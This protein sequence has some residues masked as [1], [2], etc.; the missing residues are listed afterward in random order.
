MRR[1]DG[2]EKGKASEEGEAGKEDFEEGKEVT[3]RRALA[4]QRPFILI[5]VSPLVRLVRTQRV[6]GVRVAVG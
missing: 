3:R 1:P 4:R 5:E 6:P 2:Q